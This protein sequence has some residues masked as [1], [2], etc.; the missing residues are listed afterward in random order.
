MISQAHTVS[1][2][3]IQSIWLT[4]H[5]TAKLWTKEVL[6]NVDFRYIYNKS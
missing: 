4:L 5:D 3:L 6:N 1:H 2:V